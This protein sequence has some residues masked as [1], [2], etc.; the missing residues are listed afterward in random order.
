MEEKISLYLSEFVDFDFKI[1][2]E[3]SFIS[4][5]KTYN[6]DKEKQTEENIKISRGEETIFKW[7]F[8]LAI[9]QLIIDGEIAYN[10]VKYIYIDDPISS[11]DEQ[12]SITVA[13]QINTLCN[14]RIWILNL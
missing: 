11:L 14:R 4:F 3:N 12:N 1:D 6:D 2:Y 7:C 8:F 13:Y 10:W 5:Y 9:V